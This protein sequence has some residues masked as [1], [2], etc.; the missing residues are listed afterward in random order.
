MR[1]LLRLALGAFV[2]FALATGPALPMPHMMGMDCHTDCPECVAEC[3]CGPAVAISGPSGIQV[4]PAASPGPA[5]RLLAAPP[6]A[7]GP[8]FPGT[9]TRGPP[10]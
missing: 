10:A 1:F 9:P 6:A 4:A 8:G 5:G 3:C 2:V 7:A